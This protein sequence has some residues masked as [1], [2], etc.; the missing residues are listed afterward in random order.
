MVAEDIVSDTL[1]LLWQTMKQE[2]VEFPKALLV[3]ILRNNTLNYLKHKDI[4]QNVIETLSL[5]MEHDLDYRVKSLEACEPEELFSTEIR[6]IIEA[7]LQSL[8]EQTRRVFELSRFDCLPV[9]KIAQELS[10][11]TK[12]VE[13][14]ITKSLK[15]LRIALKDYLP[16]FYLLA[17]FTDELRLCG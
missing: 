12:S 2:T 3:K 15:A 1:I 4:Q 8:P 13:Y 6:E 14:H 11:G 9:K 7:T 17:Y 5:R 10:I 16:V